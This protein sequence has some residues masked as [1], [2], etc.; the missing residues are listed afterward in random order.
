MT[1]MQGGGVT[2]STEIP[3]STTTVPPTSTTGIITTVQI[4]NQ[5]GD[6][7]VLKMTFSQ[8]VDRR[9]MTLILNRRIMK[10]DQAKGPET[11]TP[12]DEE[13]IATEGIGKIKTF[14]FIFSNAFKVFSFTFCSKLYD[15]LHRK[16]VI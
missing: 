3:D 8:G 14:D 5:E 12:K 10:V 16:N 4:G 13:V 9:T 7:T 1:R 11:T 2:I 6:T 15:M